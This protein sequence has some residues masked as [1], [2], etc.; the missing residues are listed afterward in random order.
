MYK[1]QNNS[2]QRRR[3]KRYNP[4]YPSRI[5][6]QVILILCAVFLIGGVVGAAVGIGAYRVI[7]K[8]D[9]NETYGTIGVVDPGKINSTTPSDT[10][11]GESV[12]KTGK[13]I[14]IDP[15]HGF[16]DGGAVSNLVSVR[17][18]DIN[19]KFSE[20]LKNDLVAIGFEVIFTHEG[21]SIP[22]GYDYDNDGVFDEVGTVNGVS[23]SERRD[24]A[25]SFSPDYFISIHCNSFVSN[26]NVGGMMLYYEGE[27][28]S[29]ASAASSL[30]MA[31]GEVERKYLPVASARAE[32]KYGDDI[33]AVTRRW[34]ETPAVLAELGYMTNPEDAVYLQNDEWLGAVSKAFAKAISDYFSE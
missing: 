30:V 23:R 8:N 11:D 31:M 2:S 29:S 4:G 34:G 18:Y 14:C 20:M 25:M 15:G 33:Y 1:N 22:E 17:E 9:N 32:G 6:G 5:P 21:K 27:N 26:S 28:Q 24:V 19:K 7:G 13:L 16:I 12:T 3:M 10:S